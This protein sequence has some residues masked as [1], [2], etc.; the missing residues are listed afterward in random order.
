VQRCPQVLLTGSAI[1][2]VILGEC[3]NDLDLDIFCTAR[4]V[5]FVQSRLTHLGYEHFDTKQ[6]NY[7]LRNKIP[8]KLLKMKKL[9]MLDSILY[10]MAPI[11]NQVITVMVA[12]KSSRDARDLLSVFDFKCCTAAF[13]GSRFFIPDPHLTFQ[14]I[15]AVDWQ[16]S[17]MMHGFVHG[18]RFFHFKNVAFER[19]PRFLLAAISKCWSWWLPCV[20]WTQLYGSDAGYDSAEYD[21]ILVPMPYDPDWYGSLTS[22]RA[23]ETKD[24][25]FHIYRY[26]ED[27][28]YREEELNIR[29]FSSVAPVPHVNI[30]ADLFRMSKQSSWMKLMNTV[31]TDPGRQI[32]VLM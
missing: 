21:N 25:L 17:L 4:A 20:L 32:D 22:Q 1:L 5:N 14:R 12:V 27:M 18:L 7:L 3:W 23:A 10:F 24:S 26:I 19:V 13:D 11:H 31:E 8:S 29:G 30:V 6:S 9:D 28:I 15:T 2:Q 16:C